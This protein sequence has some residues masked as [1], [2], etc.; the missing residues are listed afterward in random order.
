[1]KKSLSTHRPEANTRQAEKVFYKRLEQDYFL[2][3]NIVEKDI[4]YPTF[5]M[6]SIRIEKIECHIGICTHMHQKLAKLLDSYKSLL[7]LITRKNGDVW[8]QL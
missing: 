1:M 4:V 6:V 2:L 5:S 7:L 3:R 8:N